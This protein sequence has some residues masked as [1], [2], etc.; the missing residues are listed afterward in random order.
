MD[1]STFG[2]NTQNLVIDTSSSNLKLAVGG[3]N[4]K[5][6]VVMIEKFGII[7][8]EADTINDG[9]IADSFGIVMALKHAIA[10]LDNSCPKCGSPLEHVNGCKQCSN[11]DCHYGACDI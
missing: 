7:P 8:L 6:G 5:T 11:S 3:Y 1:F 10:K 9:Q 4:P 2:R